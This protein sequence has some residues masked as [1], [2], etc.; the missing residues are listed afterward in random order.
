MSEG[1]RDSQRDR[2]MQRCADGD[3]DKERER[4]INMYVQAEGKN[5]QGQEQF[6]RQTERWPGRERDKEGTS[7]CRAR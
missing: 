6:E 5:S 3:R 4:K 7:G 1:A 2:D